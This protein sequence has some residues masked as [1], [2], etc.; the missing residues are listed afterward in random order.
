MFDFFYECIS[1]F[2]IGFI[3]IHIGYYIHDT[4]TIHS[5][6]NTPNNDKSKNKYDSISD[7]KNELDTLDLDFDTDEKK[8]EK[9]DEKT[10]EKKD[11]K[12]DEKNDHEKNE[13]NDEKRQDKKNEKK[14]K[15]KKNNSLSSMDELN[16]IKSS[17]NNILNDLNEKK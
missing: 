7:L 14:I 12:T 4:Y 5:L 16:D 15:I 11:E 17:L 6:N 8:D 1:I 2:I 10:D 13:K 3:I 9:K